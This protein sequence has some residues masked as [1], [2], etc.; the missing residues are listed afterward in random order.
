MLVLIKREIKM[1]FGS[2][3]EP[4]DALN[5]IKLFENPSPFILSNIHIDSG[6]LPMIIQN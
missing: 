2:D 3:Q 6:L 1:F 4:N 5:S